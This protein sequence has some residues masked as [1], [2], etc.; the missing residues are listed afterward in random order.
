VEGGPGALPPGVDLTAF[1]IIEEALSEAREHGGCR[2]VRVVLRYARD[3][4]EL[5]VAHD[6]HRPGGDSGRYRL[7]RMRE[8]AALYGG[9]LDVRPLASERGQVIH[10]S[11][12]LDHVS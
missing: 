6:G 10:V 9:T 4:L 5:R 12:P 2:R 11:L 7:S 1:R 3:L 8:R